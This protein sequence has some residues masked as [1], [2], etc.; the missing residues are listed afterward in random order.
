MLPNI[1][2]LILL[3]LKR[4]HYF[5]EA[6]CLIRC[7]I[8]PS[9]LNVLQAGRENAS[10]LPNIRDMSTLE[11]SLFHGITLYKLAFTYLPKCAE[12]VICLPTFL[13]W[14]IHLFHT[15]IICLS[16]LLC[17]RTVSVHSFEK[18][19]SSKKGFD[20]RDCIAI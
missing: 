13:R 18:F 15:D 9:S 14:I 6:C 8:Q 12:N 20:R 4:K 2:F 19:F 11:M 1:I 5:F 17:V 16:C 7:V 3:T 10:F